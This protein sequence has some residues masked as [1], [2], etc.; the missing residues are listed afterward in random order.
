MTAPSEAFEEK[1]N[2]PTTLFDTSNSVFNFDSNLGMGI[3]GESSL[4]AFLQQPSAPS[5]GPLTSSFDQENSFSSILQ[6]DNSPNIL[7]TSANANSNGGRAND[8]PASS[9]SVSVK[10]LLF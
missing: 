2:Q 4:Q 9:D 7:G 3:L 8:A 6:M 5:A 1:N 10:R